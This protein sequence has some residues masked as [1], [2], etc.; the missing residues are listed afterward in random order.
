M[1]DS[2][3][4]HELKLELFPFISLFLCVIGV[5]AFLQNLMVMGE[6]GSTEEAEAEQA[7]IF[8]TPY[9]VDVYPGNILLSPPVSDLSER[10]PDLALDERAGLDA[11]ERGRNT[12]LTIGGFNLDLTME[13]NQGVLGV[14]FNEIVTVNRLA[15]S[16]GYPYEEYVLLV[17]HPGSTDTYHTLRAMM[18]QAEFRY[19]RVGLD[20]GDGTRPQ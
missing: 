17:V 11:I 14:L 3:A 7:Q 19:L 8:Q 16:R 5:L 13:D 4:R 6:I 2:R 18:E 1:I 10:L 9:R 20:I 15:E 12:I